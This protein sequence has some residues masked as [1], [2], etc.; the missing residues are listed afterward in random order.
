MLIITTLFNLIISEKRVP[1]SFKT[2]I[3][4]PVL[5]KGKN[6]KYMGNYR[7]ITV[8]AAFGKLL[9][10]TVLNK[11]KYDPSDLQFGFNKGFSPNI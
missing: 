11:M 2:V 4:T 9:E 5:K 6:S 10:Y 8:S 1:A 3:I 7:R